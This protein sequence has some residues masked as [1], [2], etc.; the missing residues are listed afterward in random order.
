[1]DNWQLAIGKREPSKS[2]RV[3]EVSS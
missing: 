1:M 3:D 2:A